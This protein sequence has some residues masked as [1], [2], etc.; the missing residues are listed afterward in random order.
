MAN[1]AEHNQVIVFTH[2]IFFATTLLTLFEASKRCS[3]F[4]ITDEEGKGCVT[5]A[6]G[7]RWDTLSAQGQ[8]QQ[9]D[10]GGSGDGRR[11]TSGPCSRGLRLDQVLV[12]ES[13][14]KQN[15][16]KGSRSGTNRTSE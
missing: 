16:S 14:P 5:H 8:H 6:S 7:P 3:Y 4:Q 11:G 2:D 12:Q 9:D 1:L 10:R 13:S 15:C